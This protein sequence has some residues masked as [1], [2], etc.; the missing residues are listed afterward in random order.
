MYLDRILGSGTKVNALSTLVQRSDMEF[1]ESELAREIGSS[2]SEVNRQMGDL[3][4]VGLVRMR[5]EG[6][7]KFYSI[8]R[9]HFLYSPLRSLLRN[10]E[11]V[12]REAARQ[13]AGYAAKRRGL[14]SVILFGSLAKGKIRSEYAKQPSDIDIVVVVDRDKDRMK[15]ELARFIEEKTTETY[16]I[17]V[18]PIV[19]TREEYVKGLE[20]DHF[21]I[22]VH[23]QGEVIYG[24]KPRRFS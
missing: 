13:I 14:V 12:Y 24:E 10:L 6:K 9:K 5:R 17:M 19:L 8:N 22:D 16:G 18:Y 1:M 15:K 20:K 7:G 3:V 11:D 4:G 23:A 21:V 2:V